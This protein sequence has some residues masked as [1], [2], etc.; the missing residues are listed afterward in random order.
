MDHFE[1]DL[2]CSVCYSIFEDP[3]VL[4][5]S[6]TF[7]RTC[8]ENIIHESGNLSIW[9]HL[10]IP[11]KCPTC[12]SIVELPPVGINSLP[13]NFSLMGIIE[14]YQKE[15]HPSTPT[16]TDHFRQPL[17][18]FCLLDRKLVC[19]Y[20]L[21]VGHHQGHPIDDLQN[22]YIKEKETC[23]KLIEQLTE[24]R[25]AK[26][27]IF[28]EQLEHQKSQIEQTIQQEKEIVS[29]YFENL[30][31]IV[32]SK[33]QAF[34]VTFDEVN[35]RVTSEYVPLIQKMQNLKEEQQDL[36]T[37]STYLEDEK[38]PLIFLEKV[39]ICHQRVNN[40]MKTQLP[41]IRP[42]NIQPRAGQFLTEKWS[43]VTVDH[44]ED[45][46][47]LQVK[48]CVEDH[49][50]K[51]PICVKQIKGLSQRSVVFTVLFLLTL[52]SLGFLMKDC[53]VDMLNSTVNDLP[54]VK[55][56]CNLI[57]EVCLGLH[58]LKVALE[59]SVQS[60]VT[61]FCQLISFPYIYQMCGF[62]LST[63]YQYASNSLQNL[64]P[65]ETH[66]EA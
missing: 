36:L 40:L 56:M 16:C 46:P 18:M 31:K 21:T 39:H 26:I 13:I 35:V 41:F 23:S 62:Q 30:Q 42:L 10:R 45:A 28:I 50:N 2:T 3:R 19:G 59:H 32:E 37:S 44:M 34:L 47:I 60:L 29:Q 54:Q 52:V 24:K 5:C 1:E 64:L 17:N 22:A 38:D 27:S 7:C 8:L 57:S 11:L 33:K 25:W 15:E 43:K 4:P 61:F 51:D 65:S 55:Q 14:K 63:V 12:R 53:C 9:R 20:C 66:E 49:W 58:S 48:H 6:H